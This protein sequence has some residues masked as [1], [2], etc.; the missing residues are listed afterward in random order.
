MTSLCNVLVASHE[1]LPDIDTDDLRDEIMGRQEWRGLVDD[2]R[3]AMLRGD[4]ETAVRLLD[5]MLAPPRSWEKDS[6][7]Y[8]AAMQD[9]ESARF[10]EA[11][12]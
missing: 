4:N 1:V 6:A 11:A 12:S 7:A 9:K 10:V 2:A 8:E 3:A 5:E